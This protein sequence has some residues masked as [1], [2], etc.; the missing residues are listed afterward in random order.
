LTIHERNRLSEQL[1]DEV[2]FQLEAGHGP[3]VTALTEHL[4]LTRERERLRGVLAAQA[5][6][7][8]VDDP[9]PTPAPD[10]VKWISRHR[11]ERNV[12]EV[13]VIAGVMAPAS[14][15]LDEESGSHQLFDLSINIYRPYRKV[16]PELGLRAAFYPLSFLGVELEGGVMP[17]RVVNED[18][19]A[20]GHAT[21][22][23]VRGHLLAQLPLWRITPF[24]LVGGGILGTTGA[25]GNDVDPTL[26]LGG[27]VKFHVS[28]RL[29]LRLDLRENRGARK[30]M[31]AGGTD[32]P[33]LLLGLSLTL[34]RRRTSA[35]STR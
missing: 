27:G 5:A 29:V 24:L 6:R 30:G 4:S 32:Y 14:G 7:D 22:F 18:R 31:N 20:G 3:H 9:P 35:Q 1:L 13:G 12:F 21:L 8:R 15:L 33:E 26:N 2:I 17:T 11:P 19:R 23:N 28:H 16:A 25:L 34:N 10:P